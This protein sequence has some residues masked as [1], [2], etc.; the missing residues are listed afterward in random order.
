MRVGEILS[1][2]AVRL[3]ATPPPR[4]C[5]EVAGL[6]QAEVRRDVSHQRSARAR[7]CAGPTPILSPI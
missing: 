2:R 5:D 7:L 6:E 3:A 4:E 1:T